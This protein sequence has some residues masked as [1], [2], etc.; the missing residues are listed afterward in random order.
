MKI[1]K[2][3]QSKLCGNVDKTGH[4][5]IKRRRRTTVNNLYNI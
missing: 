5:L 4:A 1:I 3:F 2:D